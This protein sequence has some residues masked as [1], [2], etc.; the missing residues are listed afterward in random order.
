[1]RTGMRIGMWSR[2]GVGL[3]LLAWLAAP[4]GATP[5][6]APGFV[7]LPSLVTPGTAFGGV[8]VV[9][10]AVFV[11]QDA[12][13][14]QSIVRIDPGG[15]AT[16]LATG[17]AGL[18]GMAYDALNDRLLVGANDVGPGGAGNTVFGVPDPFGSP[19]TP[20]DAATLALAPNG[21]LPF[22]ADLAL[23]PTDPSGQTLLAT[24]ASGPPGSLLRIDVSS[25]LA[26]VV[27]PLQSIG[28]YAGGVAVDPAADAIYFGDAFGSGGS[29]VR[30]VPLS[31][32]TATALAVSGDLG[33]Q[34]DL[35]LD[36][37]GLLYSTSFANV[38]RIDPS[39]GVSVPVASGFGFA[40]AI[41]EADGVIYALDFGV[42]EIYR[43]AVPEPATLPC[44]LLGLAG[45][46]LRR[47]R[48]ES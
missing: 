17:F 41:D 34:F 35:A 39:T 25:P 9:D 29:L 24:E 32:P 22:A 13:G 36:G 31:D 27:T 38:L 40:T 11:G 44:L 21:T 10:G 23:D 8:V 26:P 46:A 12:F 14:V 7:Q 18:S 45:L 28:G 43:F 4:A 30:A 2:L 20:P 48:R 6:A 37:D 1:M 19:A 42:T 3:A 5:T 33:G 15:G 47:R 16:T